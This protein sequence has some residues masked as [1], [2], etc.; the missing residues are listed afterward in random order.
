[1]GGWMPENYF[2][3]SGREKR[4]SLDIPFYRTFPSIL[5]GIGATDVRAIQ[6]CQNRSHVLESQLAPRCR[7]AAS[8]IDRGSACFA[9]GLAPLDLRAEAPSGVHTAGRDSM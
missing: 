8:P 1:M 4:F 5:K 3:R 9:L 7:K 2:W 6:G